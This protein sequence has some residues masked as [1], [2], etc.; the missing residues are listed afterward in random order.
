VGTKVEVL[1]LNGRQRMC[2]LLAPGEL[3][4]M[5]VEFSLGLTR[6]LVSDL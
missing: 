5:L 1:R 3:R 6:L 4:L 2:L